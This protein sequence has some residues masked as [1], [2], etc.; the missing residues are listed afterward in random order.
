MLQ[1]LSRHHR[2]L[3]H[4]LL[5]SFFVRDAR[6]KRKNLAPQPSAAT[7]RRNRAPQPGAATERTLA[8]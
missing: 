4:S 8:N 3:L 7:G 2:R 1:K 5:V 6:I